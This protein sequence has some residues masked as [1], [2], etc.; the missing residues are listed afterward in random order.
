[1]ALSDW[2]GRDQQLADIV[3][4]IKKVFADLQAFSAKK[5]TDSTDKD[6]EA[7]KL[8]QESSDL[9]DEAVSAETMAGDLQKAL[10]SII[11]L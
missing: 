8:A 2:L 7:K 4:P 1:M 11:S 6:T 5:R 9:L 3:A 10:P